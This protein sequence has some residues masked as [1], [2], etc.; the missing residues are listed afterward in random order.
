MSH[1]IK[2]PG[3]NDTLPRTRKTLHSKTRDQTLQITAH[4]ALTRCY[5]T[6]APRPLLQSGAIGTYHNLLSCAERR[7]YVR[8]HK[9]DSRVYTF[10]AYHT[11]H[12]LMSPI[13]S[14]FIAIYRNRSFACSTTLKFV[15]LPTCLTIWYTT[16]IYLCCVPLTGHSDNILHGV[17]LSHDFVMWHSKY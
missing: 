4:K 1:F 10:V 2:R 12:S 13:T 16:L 11:L 17:A 15:I 5:S 14:V 7:I 9:N 8:C 3:L 6:N